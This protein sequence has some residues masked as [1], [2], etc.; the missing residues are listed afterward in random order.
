MKYQLVLQFTEESLDAYDRLIALDDLLID[1]LI[2]I[3]KV[4]GHDM[5]SGEANIFI[6]SDDPAGTFNLCKPPVDATGPA[7]EWKAA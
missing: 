4:D 2:E 5:G 1:A 3:A 7:Q 6:L